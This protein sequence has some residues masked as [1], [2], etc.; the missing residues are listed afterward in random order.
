MHMNKKRIKELIKE[1]FMQRLAIMEF[2]AKIAEAELHNDKG[3]LLISPDLKVKHKDSGYE[4]TVDSVD[5][6]GDDAMVRLRKPGVPRIEPPD[7]TKRMNELDDEEEVPP[8]T[9][10][11]VEGESVFTITAQEF[12][13]NYIVD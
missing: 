5:G 8:I 12:E 10:I 13:K 9:A 3:Q 11:E 2:A 1:E 6:Q 4:Y 7:V